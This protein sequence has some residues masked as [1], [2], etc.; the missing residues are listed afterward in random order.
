RATLATASLN[1]SITMA[2][3]GITRMNVIR[4]G[5]GQVTD[6]L[7]VYMNQAE[8]RTTLRDSALA[9]SQELIV[10][11]DTG[12]VAGGMLGI[13][14]SLNQEYGE[15]TS[16]TG[17]TSPGFRVRLAGKLGY[18]YQAGV[19]DVFPVQREV[20]YIDGGDSSLVRHTG[21]RRN[22]VAGSIT[23]FRVDMRDAAGNISDSYRNIRVVTFSLT[24]TFKA[25]AG[26]P[27]LMHFSSTVI[28]RNIL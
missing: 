13:T 27:N 17:D 22:V 5:R 14:D 10:F 4:A 20:I 16:V 2:G 25:P 7:T 15:I 18:A 19:P 1:R 9:G 6:T 3:F 23:Q 26:A 11:K 12:F 24:G 21:S 28:P 8:K